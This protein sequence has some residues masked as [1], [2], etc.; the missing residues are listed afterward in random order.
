MSRQNR[1]TGDGTK[2]CVTSTHKKW[3]HVKPWDRH[4]LILM[5]AGLAYILIGIAFL[6]SEVT[7]SRE[8]NLRHVLR[9]MPYDVWCAAFVVVGIISIISSRWPSKPRTLGYA[10]LTGW[11]SACAGFYIIGGLSEPM[12]TAYVAIGF[13]WGMMG[14][15]WW[16]VSGLVCP[17]NERGSRGNTSPHRHHLGCSDCGSV[18]ACHTESVV[19]GEPNRGE[20]DVSSQHG[21][22][23]VRTC[24]SVRHGDHATASKTD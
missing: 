10:T 9:V 24:Q 4:G 12:N 20:R 15:L 2:R 21:K 22:G 11:T 14:F 7:Q 6:S 8:D 13:V 17:P 16:A 18:G 1:S 3:H 5:T 19:A 23:C